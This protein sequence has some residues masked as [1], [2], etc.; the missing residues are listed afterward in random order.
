MASETVPW[1]EVKQVEDT[2]SLS[3]Q[4]TLN[5]FVDK[6]TLKG[7]KAYWEDMKVKMDCLNNKNTAMELRLMYLD[8]EMAE[9]L[10]QIQNCLDVYNHDC[11]GVEW[12]AGI[13][14]RELGKFEDV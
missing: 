9:C 8:L 10:R 6:K 11:S 14:N 2:I 13:I 1:V 7:H 12:C 3:N 4:D 5:K